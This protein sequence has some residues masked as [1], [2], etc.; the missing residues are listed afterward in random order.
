MGAGGPL[1]SGKERYGKAPL[2]GA[3]MAL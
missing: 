3:E 2:N 1:A